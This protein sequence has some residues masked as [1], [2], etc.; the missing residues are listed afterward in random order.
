M[1]RRGAPSTAASSRVVMIG[2]IEVADQHPTEG[3]IQQCP[4]P[5]V[6]ARRR[7][8]RSVG[9]RKSKRSHSTILPPAGTRRRGPLQNPVHRRLGLP[10]PWVMAQDMAPRL[11]RNWW[12][13][14]RTTGRS[15]E[16]QP[17]LL[18]GAT[19]LSRFTPNRCFP[20]ATPPKSTLGTRPQPASPGDEDMFGGLGPEPLAGR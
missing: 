2:G 3:L 10:G 1:S 18:Q 5:F 9:V 19:R 6:A 14:L 12:T 13:V 4:P 8:Y 11:R 17:P 15:A 20:S 16:G 7:K